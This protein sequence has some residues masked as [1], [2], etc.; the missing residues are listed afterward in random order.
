VHKIVAG[1]DSNDV[2]VVQQN[3]LELLAIDEGIGRQ[4]SDSIVAGIQP[5]ELIA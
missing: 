2:V 3:Y 4:D 5:N 1:I